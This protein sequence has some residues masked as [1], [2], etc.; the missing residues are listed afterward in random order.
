[1]TAPETASP[2]ASA[3]TR[4]V[5]SRV[6]VEVEPP[7][8]SWASN[9]RAKTNIEIKMGMMRE[10]SRLERPRT[11]GSNDIASSDRVLNE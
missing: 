1:M 10:W 9:G 7:S 5:S 11:L 6:S 2:A 3:T 8:G 4:P